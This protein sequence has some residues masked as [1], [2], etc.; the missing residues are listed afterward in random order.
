[1]WSMVLEKG[2]ALVA[3]TNPKPLAYD[4]GLKV[5]LEQVVEVPFQLPKE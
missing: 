1:M 5:G 3:S 2:Y 4:H